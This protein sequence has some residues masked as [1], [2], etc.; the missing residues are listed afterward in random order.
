MTH[1]AHHA[2]A[3]GD[4]FTIVQRG[5]ISQTFEKD[6]A[7]YARSGNV[8]LVECVADEQLEVLDQPFASE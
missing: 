6:E 4:T 7:G 8:G 3:A 2:N 1:N 5:R